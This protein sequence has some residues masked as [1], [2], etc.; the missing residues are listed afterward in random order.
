MIT[1][2]WITMISAFASIP[3][4]YLSWKLE[5]RIDFTATFIQTVIQLTA[6]LIF[7]TINLY[8]KKLLNAYFKFHDTDKSIDWMIKANVVAGILIVIG[9][10]STQLKD[11]F[12]IAAL[13]IMI[14][15][16]IVQIQFG[17]KLLKLQDNLGGMLKPFCY[18]NMA[19]GICIAS[20]VLI[21][22]GILVSA[23]SDLMLGTI[24]FTMAKLVKVKQNIEVADE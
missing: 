19:T 3:V 24:F 16:G 21:L 1:A 13:L 17:Y 15:Q 8:L 12:G 2:G 22:V 18:V 10:H 23:I 6:I 14:A 9:L 5:G 7:L 11:T 20:V 4:A